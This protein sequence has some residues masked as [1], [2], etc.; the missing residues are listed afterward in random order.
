MVVNVIGAWRR[1]AT[2][3]KRSYAG[4]FA[5]DDATLVQDGDKRWEL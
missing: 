3:G 5:A 2:P 1:M 4:R